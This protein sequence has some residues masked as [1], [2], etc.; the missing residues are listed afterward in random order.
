MLGN[1]LRKNMGS[2]ESTANSYFT[3]NTMQKHTLTQKSCLG[4]CGLNH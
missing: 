4:E 3:Q 1:K 2:M